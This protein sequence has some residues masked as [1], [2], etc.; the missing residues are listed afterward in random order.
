MTGLVIVAA[1][2]ALSGSEQ[3]GGSQ[4]VEPLAAAPPGSS[5]TQ[6]C[7]VA[8]LGRY[9]ALAGVSTTSV[10]GTV[11]ND[12]SATG[13]AAPNTLAVSGGLIVTLA[14]EGQTATF[15]RYS[16]A[17]RSQ[18]HF[19]VTA[20]GG[21]HPPNSFVLG[22]DGTIFAASSGQAG[23]TV[24]RYD[25]KGRVTSSW[26]L[27][28]LGRGPVAA[29]FGWSAGIGAAVAAVA[30]ED[31]PRLALLGS[32]GI[33]EQDGP[34]IAPGTYFPQQDG[35]LL[36]R[37]ELG[38]GT[39]TVRRYSPAGVPVGQFAGPAQDTSGNGGP[40]NLERPTGIAVAPH[41]GYLLAGPRDRVIE[42][43]VDGV[44]SRIALSGEASGGPVFTLAE[45]SPLVRSG[46]RYYFFSTGTD[47]KVSLSSVDLAGMDALLNAPVT[48]DVDHAATMARLG[49]GA[50]LV[51]GAPYDYFGPKDNLVVAATFDAWWGAVADTYELRYTVT[52]DPW[53]DP[54]VDP[55]S[56]TIAI[57]ANG[58][59]VDLTLPTAR[60]GPYD[61]DARLIEKATGRVRTATCLRYTVGSVNATFDPGSLA[62]GANW[63]GAGPLRGVQ[64]ADELGIGS[65]RVQLDFGSLV[66]DVGAVPDVAH[67]HL[68]SLPGAVDGQPFADIARAA[69]LARERGVLLYVQVGQGGDAERTAV[70]KG[71]WGAWTAAIASAFA[72]GAP[73][74]HLWAPWNE[75][76]N[77]GFGDGG[78]YARRVLAP[79]TTAV[80]AID[81]AAKII[82]GNALDVAVP[83][84]R[85]M[86]AAG[87]CSSLDVVGI[88]PYTG[89][90]RSWD[91][92]GADG[93]IGQIKELTTSLQGCG[94]N[95]PP[96]WDT[97][98]GWWSDGPANEWA[99]GYDVARSM[100]W[101]RYLGVEQWTYFFSEGGWGEGGVTWSLLQAESYVKPGALAM[102]T[103]SRLLAGR[104]RPELVATDIP[105]VHAMHV[106]AAA[107]GSDG[108]LAV[109]T[110]DLVT[111][112][113]LTS[114]VDSSVTVTDIY[115]GTRSIL[116]TAGRR[117]TVP[118]SGSPVFLTAASNTALALAPV[119][120]TGTN[121]LASG[122]ATASSSAAGAGP[123]AVLRVGGAGTS[124]WRAGTTL[125]DGAPDLSP[126]I[127]VDLPSATTID[128]VAVE[129][130]GIR[131]CTSGLRDYTVS[132]Q[133][134]DGSWHEVGARHDLLAERT[135]ILRFEP[136]TARSVRVQVPDT[137]ERGVTVPKV[138]YSG[139]TAGLH[140]A[141]SPVVPETSWP[142]SV[143]ALAAFAP[144]GA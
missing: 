110:D 42:V 93:P 82:G 89:L 59:K 29:V 85:Q 106:G 1:V 130:A 6:I 121:V 99:Q 48:Y 133:T 35:T 76:N 9:S 92:E 108:L 117:F 31:S 144:G 40:A 137:V 63:G 64:I 46:D 75:P 80:R 3:G 119:E 50:G 103:V 77:T 53:A 16:T 17:G 32:D 79:F 142:A 102:S 134:E 114:P 116:V 113:D 52:G 4:P 65:Y 44:W 112:L 54:P 96:L 78:D 47:G 83:W 51:T 68:S 55:T 105:F 2:G 73:D 8:D 24:L 100:L 135:T 141:W 14:T 25:A 5:A 30:F 140:P 109:W 115:G 111:Q 67:L 57:P 97:E 41:G 139:Q 136:L 12:V 81:P 26:D 70:D 18:G 104:P 28:S 15:V 27:A 11:V 33:V 19:A 22:P 95:P 98:S 101:M 56:G 86:I 127:Q 143:V 38:D 128:R 107:G 10:V 20:T 87:A 61:V 13:G 69:Q 45:Q 131:C 132:V 138:N 58:G 66:P 122:T 84:Y 72:T 125:T 34:E 90:N 120:P 60:P 129:S 123:A 36:V 118:V 74:V 88:H 21:G 91:E 39:I 23:S 37:S 7:G 71:T 126:W 49:Y 94:T 43:G 62:E 124:P